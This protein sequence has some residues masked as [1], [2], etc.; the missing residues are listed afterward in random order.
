MKLPSFLP[1]LARVV[2]LLSFLL[3][4]LLNEASPVFSSNSLSLVT[5]TRITTQVGMPVVITAEYLQ[6][7]DGIS[8][9]EDL[10][11]TLAQLPANGRLRFD[12]QDLQEND[13][14]TQAD[15]EA[16]RIVYLSDSNAG[17]PDAF[18]FTF[19]SPTEPAIERV[20][21][22][23]GRIQANRASYDA[24]MTA[25]GR[26]VVFSTRATNFGTEDPQEYD[27]IYVHDRLTGETVH[28]SKTQDGHPGKGYPRSPFISATGDFVTY[29]SNAP[30]LTSVPR[31]TGSSE[32]AY[33]YDRTKNLTEMMWVDQS[34]FPPN[35]VTIFPTI[36]EDGQFLALW[37][38]GYQF[39][40]VWLLNR[41]TGQYICAS[42]NA[43]TQVCGHGTLPVISGN[44]Q[45]VAFISGDQLVPED[46]NQ[47]T[48]AY[49]F[50]VANGSLVL[51]SCTP[52]GNSGNQAVLDNRT[53]SISA[54]GRFV[55]YAS[56][57]SDL[58]ANDLN[59][60]P[61]FFVFDRLGGKNE[62][63][64]V[65]NKGE[66]ADFENFTQWADTTTISGDGRYIAF[67]S[68]AKN[69]DLWDSNGK[70]DLFVR[71]R[72]AGTTRRILI[73]R[74]PGAT[75]DAFDKFTL[76]ITDDGNSLLFTS[77]A[78]WLVAGDTNG[79]K[80]VFLAKT[81]QMAIFQIQVEGGSHFPQLKYNHGLSTYERTV[82][83][84]TKAIL[85][86]GEN[87][88]YTLGS[89]P[90]R[91][92][93]LLSDQVMQLGHSFSQNDIDQ[94][95]LVFS[96]KEIGEDNIKLQ[97]GSSPLIERISIN[98]EG[99]ASASTPFWFPSISYDGKYAIVMDT[100]DGKQQVFVRD[101]SQ[102]HHEAVGPGWYGVISGNARYVVFG[103]N[104]PNLVP[105][106]APKNNESHLYRYDR[107]EKTYKIIDVDEFGQPSEK[108][109]GDSLSTTFNGEKVLFTAEDA[110]LSN[111]PSHATY[112]WHADTEHLELVSIAP[113]G[114]P[115]VRNWSVISG[116][117][118][119]VA[120]EDFLRD[121]KT[122]ST[123]PLLFASNNT[124]LSISYDGRYIA[125]TIEDGIIPGDQNG[126]MDVALYDQVLKT[127]QLVSIANDGAPANGS[128]FLPTISPDGTA[129]GFSTGATNL[130]GPKAAQTAQVVVYDR[131]K[132]E[133]RL[134]SVSAGSEPGND[135]SA[136]TAIP[137]GGKYVF[138]SS[139][140]INL[141]PDGSIHVGVYRY[142]LE[143]IPFNFQ[144]IVN[145]L[146]WY[147]LPL[148]S[149]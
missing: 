81:N 95:N 16:G 82:S 134:V 66:Q 37:S 149:K 115:L 5:N 70:V 2:L 141:V 64:T 41:S 55:S 104:E 33:L 27:Q 78:D 114:S 131:L 63:V 98:A 36:S 111:V 54:D 26:Q 100:I 35:W 50:D 84:I 125:S 23:T 121:L 68:N 91:G 8:D 99:Q 147:Y 116:D 146:M 136:Y 9:S 77:D 83:P 24:D 4:P 76:E 118:R 120:F 145:P 85:Q 102:G 90:E 1:F 79:M 48:D 112:V 75:Q 17:G 143:T 10:V 126:F 148:V 73:P 45:W 47:T 21:V 135:H 58:V 93:L 30:N 62:L 96:P 140:A 14:F 65:N 108:G 129:I 69:L 87:L 103:S 49:L 138:F 119:Y 106:I 34:N 130:G 56:L 29:S 109:I 7:S 133:S 22:G 128:S 57:A 3:L 144:I 101:L 124:P 97:L 43:S 139:R 132:E 25:D 40:S 72:Q 19:S 6:I 13:T 74:K 28:I 67:Y 12:G 46:Q 105:G 137:V 11:F 123:I 42:W 113:D 31:P 60:G 122:K 32:E 127:Y 39:D 53:P 44:G 107:V 59:E 52:Q 94:G 92:D 71:D 20:S 142:N 80:D 117:G 89:L 38:A 51:A 61:D 18:G 88:T 15:I 86:A 110:L